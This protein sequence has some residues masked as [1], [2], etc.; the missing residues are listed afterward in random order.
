MVTVEEAKRLLFDKVQPAAIIEVAI[1]NAL[2]CV[3]AE[4]VHSPIDLPSF[5][6]S[7]MDG[8]AVASGEDFAEKEFNIIGEVKAGDDPGMGV[9]DGQCVRIFTGAAIPH[10]ADAVVIQEKVEEKNGKIFLYESFKKGACIRTQG[11]QIKKGDI[12]L[13]Q[14]HILNPASIG[15]LAALGI[16]VVKTYRKPV[17]S[18]IVTGSEIISAGEELK[19]GKVYES[20]SFSLKAALEQMDIGVEHIFKAED[21]KQALKKKMELGL[22][23][24]DV[25]ILTGG[26]SVGK[27]DLV[28][29]LLQ[30]L[31]V[32]TIFYKVSQKPGKPFFAGTINNKMVFALPGNPAS[33]MVCFYEY[34][35]PAINMMLGFSEIALQKLKLKSFKG[36]KKTE[37]RAVFLR[38]KKVNNEVIELEGQDSNMLRSFAEANAFIYLPQEVQQVNRGEEVEVHLLPY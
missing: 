20:N 33:G 17:V 29:D 37:G 16:S 4:T 19:K 36:I 8:Y 10:G 26:I 28:Y 18:I 5:D 13:P 22:A 6:Q 35:Y 32:K 7:S 11:S 31:G 9:R 25:L 21:E 34:V 12:A 2:N 3:L 24:S 14:G 27:Y 30:E 38:A 1:Q 15:F 23:E